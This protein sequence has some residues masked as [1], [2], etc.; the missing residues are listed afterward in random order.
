MG[1]LIDLTGRR[2]GRLT[3]IKRAG[4]YHPP[5]RA[6]VN[7]PLWLCR[8]DCGQEAVVIGHNLRGGRTISCGCYRAEATARRSR[9]RARDERK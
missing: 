8:C 1:T 5:G 3:V 7:E 6:W 9:E 4:S 2:F